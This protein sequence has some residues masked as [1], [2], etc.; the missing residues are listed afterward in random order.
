MILK[1]DEIKP[2]DCIIKT[3]MRNCALS[4][5]DNGGF[6]FEIVPR[7]SNVKIFYREDPEVYNEALNDAFPK[8][9]QS[10]VTVV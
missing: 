8:W 7:E 5:K 9:Y 1:P 2:D 4:V 10:F 6:D 3:E